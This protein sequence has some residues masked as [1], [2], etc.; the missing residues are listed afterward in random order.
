MEIFGIINQI[1]PPQNGENSNGSWKKQEFIIQTLDKYPKQI[2]ISNWKD[3]VKIE[4]FEIGM[5][6]K[7]N[8]ELESR[9]HNERWY[10]DIKVWKMEL[11][12]LNTNGMA[13]QQDNMDDDINF[14]SFDDNNPF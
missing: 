2:C 12:N 11:L 7:L 5:L 14:K 1:M 9:C 6:V 3:K 8:V 10:N 4:N 13:K